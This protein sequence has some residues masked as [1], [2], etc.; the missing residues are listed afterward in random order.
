MFLY[1]S[2]A[3]F[4][5]KGNENADCFDRVNLAIVIIRTI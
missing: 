1:P 2:F 5:K 3:I 4:A